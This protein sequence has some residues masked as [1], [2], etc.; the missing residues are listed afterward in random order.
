M[1]DDPTSELDD[2]LP[3]YDK[4]VFTEGISKFKFLK[5]HIYVKSDAVPIF[6]KAR[7]VL[8]AIKAVVEELANLEKQGIIKK[9][10]SVEWAAPTVNVPK[11]NGV[12]IC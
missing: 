5:A 10:D 8:Y 9:I 11:K 7:P 6:K 12:H 4:A 2:I 3:R 1:V